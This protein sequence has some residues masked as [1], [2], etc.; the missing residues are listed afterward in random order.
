MKISMPVSMKVKE[1]SKILDISKPAISQKISKQQED[2]IKSNSNK[3][4]GIS[5]EL[6]Y[7]MLKE[8]GYDHFY[9]KNIFLFTTIVGGSSKTSSCWNLFN[10]YIRMSSKK[11]PV[12][13]VSTDSQ[14]SIDEI[15][16]KKQTNV[17]NQKVLV[18]YYSERA[19][20]DE[21]LTCINEEENLWLLRSSLNN[22]FLDK[23]LSSPKKIKEEGLRLIEDIYKKF[24]G[25][26]PSIFIDTMPALSS[27]T[28][29]LELAMSQLMKKFSN[30]EYNPIIAIPLR[31]DQTSLSGAEM[32]VKE[33][34]T[35]LETFGLKEM[36]TMK[37]YL[38]NYDKRMSISNEILK[39]LFSN[40]L[41]NNF[42]AETVIRTSTEISKKAYINQSTFHDKLTPITEDYTELLLEFLGY[43]KKGAKV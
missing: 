40:D 37:V 4:L 11:N 19:T 12:V 25:T 42:V 32:A 13:I 14:S 18:D 6:I 39:S 21:V 33:L 43:E 27:S 24:E 2:L 28:A 22:V 17:G 5:R 41:L 35:A 26:N 38:A 8:Q 15:I 16:L 10:A 9:R 30:K 29:T 1:I 23:V 7:K 36:P 34:M 3:T 31:T 20:I